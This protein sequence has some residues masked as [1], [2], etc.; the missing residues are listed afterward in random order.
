MANQAKHTRYGNR[1]KDFLISA[2]I[3]PMQIIYV[4]IGRFA[5]YINSLNSSGRRRPA[6]IN[7][8][9]HP[10]SNPAATL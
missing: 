4:I 10:T 7:H 6:R 3:Y 2:K 5:Y 1:G 8:L 9:P